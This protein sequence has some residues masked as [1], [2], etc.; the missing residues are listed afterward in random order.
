LQTRCVLAAPTTAL[1][2]CHPDPCPRS[3]QVP[4]TGVSLLVTS[5]YV[6]VEAVITQQHG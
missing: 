4:T 5:A 6:G 1:H 3:G 2:A